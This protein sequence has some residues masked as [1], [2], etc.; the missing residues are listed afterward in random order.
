MADYIILKD[1]DNRD[2]YFKNFKGAPGMYNKE[3]DRNFGVFISDEMAYELREKGWN[4]KSVTK[5][6]S[7]NFGRSYLKV[8]VRLNWRPTPKIYKLTSK[9]KMRLDEETLED[10]DD[11]IFDRIDMKITRVYLKRY[12]QWT[13][14]LEKGF[15]TMAEDELDIMYPDEFVPFEE[16][17]DNP[18]L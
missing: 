5:E 10:L 2:I 12:D 9:N 1:L 3:G 17:D 16:E 18:F 14:C 8:L 11:Y 6:D 15:F 13:Q 7:P 4:V